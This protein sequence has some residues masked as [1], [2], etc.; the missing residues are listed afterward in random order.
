[1]RTV[2]QHHRVIQLKVGIK[3]LKEDLE[4][5]TAVIA[6]LGSE[7]VLLADANGAWDL[8]TATQAVAGISDPR[9]LIEEPCRSYEDNLR[10]S[11]QAPVLFDQCIADRD[12]A[13]QAMADGVSRLCIK[14]AF[15]GG[16]SV[17]A[18]IAR[19]ASSAGVTVRVD[20]PWCGDI[21]TA[22]IAHLATTIPASSLLC[23][24]DLR[25]PLTL[26]I[27]LGVVQTPRA[28]STAVPARAG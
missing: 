25:E 8:E 6:E 15:L 24:C 16:L 26:P 23:G 13:L 1:L 5:I 21:A 14:P 9:V 10:V 4:A 18:D 17:A 2:G 12:A 28:G 11:Q 20:G 3:S 19:R 27:D 22:A 7:Q